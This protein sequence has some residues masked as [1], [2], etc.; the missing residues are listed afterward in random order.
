MK[1]ASLDFKLVFVLYYFVCFREQDLEPSRSSQGFWL[2]ST[3]RNAVRLHRGLYR[4]VHCAGWRSRCQ[5]R[6]IT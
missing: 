1:R 4:L 2:F 3:I 6:A 5:G